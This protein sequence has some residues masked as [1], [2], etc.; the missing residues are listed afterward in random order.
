MRLEGAPF[1]MFLNRFIFAALLWGGIASGSL[2]GW[3][4]FVP[5]MAGS[6]IGIQLRPKFG[7]SK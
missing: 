3:I 1:L 6:F 5:A 4:W 7:L 2:H